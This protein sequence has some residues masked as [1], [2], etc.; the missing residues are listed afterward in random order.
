MGCMGKATRENSLQLNTA[1][2]KPA[3]AGIF[4]TLFFRVLGTSVNSAGEADELNTFN[5]EGETA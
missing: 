4:L 3:S 5:E 2:T 1:L